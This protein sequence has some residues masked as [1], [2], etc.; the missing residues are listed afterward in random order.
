M[1][2]IVTAPLKKSGWRVLRNDK[3]ERVVGVLDPGRYLVMAYTLFGMQ[4]YDRVLAVQAAVKYLEL[5]TQSEWL[6]SGTNATRRA[7]TK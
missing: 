4:S 3:T 1:S 5:A 7:C 6:Q 2:R